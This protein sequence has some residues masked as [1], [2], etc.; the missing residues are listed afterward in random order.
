MTRAQAMERLPKQMSALNRWDNARLNSILPALPRAVAAESPLLLQKAVTRDQRESKSILAR[1]KVI[2]AREG[3]PVRVTRKALASDLRNGGNKG[4]GAFALKALA[5]SVESIDQFRVRC[6]QWAID[7]IS[8][9]GSRT[10]LVRYIVARLRGNDRY[11][12]ANEL[13]ARRVPIGI[14]DVR[15]PPDHQRLERDSEKED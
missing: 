7:H 11:T 2:R 1:S 13:I 8:E 5:E 15:D 9:I 6:I 12:R 3:R 14:D 10:K 4:I